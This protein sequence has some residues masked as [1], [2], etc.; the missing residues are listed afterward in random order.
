VEVPVNLDDISNR[1]DAVLAAAEGTIAGEAIDA[2]FAENGADDGSLL[3]D[4]DPL[5]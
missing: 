3:T 4:D 2:V 1:L 5:A